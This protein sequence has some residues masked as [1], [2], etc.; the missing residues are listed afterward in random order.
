MLYAKTG[1][2]GT[3]Q[4]KNKAGRF[5]GPTA[6]AVSAAAVTATVGKPADEPYSLHE[7]TYSLTDSDAPAAYP[8]GGISYAILFEQQPADPGKAVVEFLKWVVTDGQQYAKELEYAP[9]PDA[10][11]TRAVERLGKVT[12]K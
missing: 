1:S 2:L 9:L 4:L 5:V 6:E 11:R 7:L 3:A 10:L 12:F 8:I